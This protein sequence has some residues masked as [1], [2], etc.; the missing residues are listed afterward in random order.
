MGEL[1]TGLLC[2]VDILFEAYC[3]RPGPNNYR[4]RLQLQHESNTIEVTDEEPRSEPKRG[5]NFLS[6]EQVGEHPQ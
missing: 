6:G 4:I 5:L 2:P 1:C 3:F